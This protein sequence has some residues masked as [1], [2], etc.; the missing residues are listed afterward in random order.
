MVAYQIINARY[1][2]AK[3]QDPPWLLAQ[4]SGERLYP[5]FSIFG[6]DSSIKKSDKKTKPDKVRL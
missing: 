6:G 2:L 3:K 1:S 4:Y 5:A